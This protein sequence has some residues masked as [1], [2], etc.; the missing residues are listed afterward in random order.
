MGSG[1]GNNQWK[2][3]DEDYNAIIQIKFYSM[4]LLGNIVEP[5]CSVSLKQSKLSNRTITMD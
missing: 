1:N 4:M 2:I 5:F 3:S